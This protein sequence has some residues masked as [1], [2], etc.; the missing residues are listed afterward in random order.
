MCVEGRKLGKKRYSDVL[1]AFERPPW[2]P[3]PG[4]FQLGNPRALLASSLWLGITNYEWSACI[5]M[6][7]QQQI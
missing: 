1:T 3:G 4:T 6:N 2:S 5:I 7:G